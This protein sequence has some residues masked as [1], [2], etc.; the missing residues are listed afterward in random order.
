MKFDTDYTNNMQYPKKYR[1]KGG[2]IK[3]KHKKQRLKALFPFPD[4]KAR[5]CSK[6][7][8]GNNG[9]IICANFLLGLLSLY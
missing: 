9:G 1:V 4:E 6:R 8:G 3:E 2:G 7:A 5:A